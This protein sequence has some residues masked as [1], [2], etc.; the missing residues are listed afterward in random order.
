MKTYVNFILFTILL[1]FTSCKFNNKNISSKNDDYNKIISLYPKELRSIFPN[2]ENIK[3]DFSSYINYSSEF[4]PLQLIIEQ[5]EDKKQINHLKSISQLIDKS[6]TTF[7]I[8]NKFLRNNNMSKVNRYK[9]KIQ[10]FKSTAIPI[11]NF[12]DLDDFDET[13]INLLNND[14]TLFSLESRAGICCER[15]LH[16]GNWNMP[17]EWE[18]GYSIG[19]A[20]NDINNKVIYWAVI[21]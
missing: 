2:I 18:N 19:Y 14:Y 9:N 4:S 1:L 20:I 21:W 10:P 6:D 7:Y 12:C 15:K 8:V 5:K 3:N 11:P 16:K 13:S 17:I